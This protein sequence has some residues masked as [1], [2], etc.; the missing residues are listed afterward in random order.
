MPGSRLISE[1]TNLWPYVSFPVQSANCQG[2]PNDNL[3]VK[4]PNV[5]APLKF[6]GTLPSLYRSA[7]E[8]NFSGGVPLCVAV[9]IDFSCI[10][11][12]SSSP[13]HPA[14]NVQRCGNQHSRHA[15]PPITEETYHLEE[16]RLRGESGSGSVFCKAKVGGFSQSPPTFF[17]EK[18]AAGAATCQFSQ[19]GPSGPPARLLCQE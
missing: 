17:K 9:F 6:S 12:T 10:S 13:C 19:N 18:A 7:G 14:S 4:N 2:P 8:E 5:R 15:S 11:S 16:L 1:V 3:G